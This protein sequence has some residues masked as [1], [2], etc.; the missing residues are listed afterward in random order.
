MNS[1]IMTMMAKSESNASV[2]AKDLCS[3]DAS[4]S[5]NPYNFNNSSSV[6]HST[7]SNCIPFP[8]KLYDLLEESDKQGYE[9]I[10]SWMPEGSSS[11]KIYNQRE[12]TQTLMRRYFKQTHYKSFQR[13]CK[14]SKEW[15]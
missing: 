4:F 6:D 15:W 11:F 1:L 14:Y 7:L 3:Y 12:F 10:I 2:H 13:Q 9:A 8:F 5:C